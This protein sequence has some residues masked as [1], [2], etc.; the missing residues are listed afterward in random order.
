[1]AGIDDAYARVLKLTGQDQTPQEM[2]DYLNL[3]KERQGKVGE[4]QDFAGRASLAKAFLTAGANPRGLLAGAIEGGQSYLTDA[5][6]NREKFD[7]L[8]LE[9]GKAMSDY[10]KSEIERNKGNFDAA[11][12]LYDKAQDRMNNLEIAKMQHLKPTE[13]DKMFA[14]Y[15]AD[16]KAA[17]RVATYEGFRKAYT[18]ADEDLVRLTKADAAIKAVKENMEYMALANSKKPEDKQ[19]AAAMIAEVYRRYNIDPATG[20]VMG[21][22]TASAGGGNRLKFDASG[23][24]I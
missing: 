19:K 2:T 5:A 17:G 15:S 4:L 3:L 22:Q 10:K 11:E 23:K 24:Q 9:Y 18:G 20:A 1:M 7:K 16:E 12:K 13:F 8:G 14:Q 21:S 6:A